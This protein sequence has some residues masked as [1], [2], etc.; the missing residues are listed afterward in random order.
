MFVRVGDGVCSGGRTKTKS[1]SRRREGSSGLPALAF[2]S[3]LQL[4]A[5]F[6]GHWCSAK[7]KRSAPRRAVHCSIRAPRCLFSG[8][9]NHVPAVMMCP[10][11]ICGPLGRITHTISGSLIE[12]GAANRHGARPACCKKPHGSC[13]HNG[14][15]LSV[16]LLLAGCKICF[17]KR[18][19]HKGR[20]VKSS[21]HT[22]AP[23][24]GPC[25]HSHCFFVC[26]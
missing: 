21:P 3:L 22:T 12:P 24:H 1:V 14:L 18:R 8:R 19:T 10:P 26:M 20:V 13:T 9:P 15:S 16:S 25:F 17:E 5:A 6:F 7:G 2:P 4:R 23:G 11:P